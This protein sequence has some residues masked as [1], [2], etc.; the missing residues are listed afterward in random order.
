MG[1]KEKVSVVLVG[2]ETNWCEIL[3]KYPEVKANIKEINI[4]G[5][6]IGEGNASPASEFNIY[7]DPEATDC[8][9][10]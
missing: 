7:A 10:K 1:S 3:R 9:L 2:P 5:G 4:M 8:V 6:A